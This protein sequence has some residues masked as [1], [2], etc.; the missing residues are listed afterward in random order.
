MINLIPR[1]MQAMCISLTEVLTAV[2]NQNSCCHRVRYIGEFEYDTSTN[3]SPRTVK[4]LNDLPIKVAGVAVMYLRDVAT[5]S[6]A[7]APQTNIVRQDGK[8]GQPC[9]RAQG[10]Y[11]LNH[12][13]LLP[14]ITLG[15]V[16]PVRSRHCQG[17]STSVRHSEISP[18]S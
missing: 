2:T 17:N 4:E 18:S 12:R 9:D 11:G 7:Y 14:V 3:A 16:L 1:L 13:C 10:R 5:V 6:D 8:R 15:Q